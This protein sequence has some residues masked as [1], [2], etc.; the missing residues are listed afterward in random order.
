M[1]ILNQGRSSLTL[2]ILGVKEQLKC[3]S[4]NFSISTY[5]Y[6]MV[7]ESQ[8]QFRMGSGQR[9]LLQLQARTK[10]KKKTDA[11]PLFNCTSSSLTSI[12]CQTI[13]FVSKF[14]L[15]FWVTNSHS[16][17][18]SQH[19]LEIEVFFFFFSFWISSELFLYHF[20]RVP[21]LFIFPRVTWMDYT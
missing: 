3:V 13:Q 21:S 10:E 16:G 7:L 4:K 12:L 6:C 20:L 19:V 14:L 9:A 8:L 5:A 11:K 2:Q 1:L 17:I 18:F 15:V